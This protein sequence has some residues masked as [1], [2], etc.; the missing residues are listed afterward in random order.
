MFEKN[1]SEDP[2][3]CFII[4]TKKMLQ[5]SELLS[6]GSKPKP[7]LVH[8]V[9]MRMSYIFSIWCRK[10]PTGN[11]IKHKPEDE[12]ALLS[13]VK[14][15]KVAHG[16]LELEARAWKEE[17]LPA[18]NGEE[19]KIGCHGLPVDRFSTT[20]NT[21]YQFHS[22]FWHTNPCFKTSTIGEN[23]PIRKTPISEVNVETLKIYLHYTMYFWTE[24][25]IL[26]ILCR[27]DTPCMVWE[28][29]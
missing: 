8:Y 4:T 21:V 16:W 5:K 1:L 12:F 20:T 24:I 28:Q 19:V 29:I 13:T 2:V 11:P 17:I 27:L 18:M 15:S 7:V 10:L 3:L 22:Y 25:H 9:L 14:E 26:N 6:M 23:H